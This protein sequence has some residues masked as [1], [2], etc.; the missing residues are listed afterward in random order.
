M[1]LFKIA[2]LALLAV[3]LAPAAAHAS[4]IEHGPW[5]GS[6]V[7]V[8][9]LVDKGEDTDNLATWACW[10]NYNLSH[11][12]LSKQTVVYSGKL[13]GLYGKS[14]GDAEY[15]TLDGMK[16]DARSDRLHYKPTYFCY[17][18]KKDQ[19]SW[20]CFRDRHEGEFGQLRWEKGELPKGVE[21]STTY[22]LDETD[23]PDGY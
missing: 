8:T 19:K 13:G 15:V 1:R 18:E 22:S 20:T 9:C 4:D 3:L 14:W 10:K 17:G 16:K 11:V 23:G 21:D 2:G 5:Y 7:K 6:T 12:K